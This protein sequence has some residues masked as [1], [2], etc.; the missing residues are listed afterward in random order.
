MYCL[1]KA[2]IYLLPGVAI[3]YTLDSALV[4]CSFAVLT[5][6]GR[7]S[8]RKGECRVL[9]QFVSEIKDRD[10]V[11]AVFLVKDK[12]LAMAKNGIDRIT[13]FNLTDE[14]F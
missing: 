8:S 6:P 14:L 13:I 4:Y 5:S 10:T 3:A 1:I 9:K 11:N 12:I 7:L 2:S